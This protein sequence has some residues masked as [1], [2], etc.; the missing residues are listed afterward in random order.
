MS[1]LIRPALR[2]YRTWA[3]DS[4][5]WHGYRP[6]RG[7]IVV[8]T[9]PKCGTTWMQRIVG[10]L[11]TGSPDPVAIADNSPWIEARFRGPL[12][13]LLARLDAQTGRRV[14]DPSPSGWI[15]ALR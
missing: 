11:L 15:A 10:L 1:E 7:D 8:C 9:Y 5:R 2:Q 12:E 13:P 6:R 4:A 3:V 14:L